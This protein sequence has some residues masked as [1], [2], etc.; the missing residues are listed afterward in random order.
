MPFESSNCFV[1][2]K[3]LLAAIV[4]ASFQAWPV[5]AAQAQMMYVVIISRHGV[6]APT[7]NAARL[8]EYSSKPWPN[9]GVPPGY[10]TRHGRAAI[11]R[12]GAYYRAWFL[13]ER[14]IH[15]SGCQDAER[16]YIG[17][18]TDER[19]LETGRAFAESLFPGCG[20]EVHS[21]PKGEKDRLFSGSGKQ[22]PQKSL[23]ALRKRLRPASE[24][25]LAKAR[26]SF[27]MLQS[28]LRGGQPTEKQ[29]PPLPPQITAS[30]RGGKVHL[31]G[32]FH[33]ASSLSESLLLEYADG[34]RGRDLGWGRLTK[35]NLMDV[36][37]LHAIYA[38]L[39]RS[40]PYLARARGSNLLQTIFLSMEQ[41]ETGKTLPR[42]LGDRQDRVLI[43]VGHDTNLSNLSGMLRLSWHLPGYL[44][45]ATP[46][47]AALIFS[48]WREP[49]SEKYFVRTQFVAQSLDQMRDLVPLSLS[50]PAEQ[51]D[52]SIPGCHSATAGGGCPWPV[53]E[54]ALHQAIDPAF[55]TEHR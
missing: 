17:A 46:P 19:T 24:G 6:R 43:L 33:I 44:A 29:L 47:G 49:R 25:L 36:L 38:D 22:N 55:G 48:L 23:E 18:D 53:F 2:F 11:E 32:P 9:W 14:L 26:P 40:T 8:N 54:A 7:W 41:A 21:L 1:K 12:M 27:H 39:T 20:L 15:H 45:N 35:E 31:N 10:L 28:I 52:L 16:V 30:L 3:L 5:A 13:N 34:M 42:A 4:L 51:Q 50:T 37:T